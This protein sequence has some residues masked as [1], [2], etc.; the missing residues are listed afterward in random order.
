MP[1]LAPPTVV[2]EGHSEPAEQARCSMNGVGHDSELARNDPVVSQPSADIFQ[3][4]LG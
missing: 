2:V 4:A 1:R 3:N